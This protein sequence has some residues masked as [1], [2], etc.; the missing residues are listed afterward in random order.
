MEIL[1]EAAPFLAG[2][3]VPVIAAVVLRVLPA[4]QF[5]LLTVLVLSFVVGASASFLN[6]ELGASLPDSLMALIIDT[7]LVYT[8]SQIAYHAFWKSVLPARE[9]VKSRAAV[10]E[11]HK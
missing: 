4:R 5:T 6:G 9:Q 3:I 2:L 8:G 11:A 1:R 10:R 7:S